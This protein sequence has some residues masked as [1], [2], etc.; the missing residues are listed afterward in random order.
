MTK[1]IFFPQKPN[2][3]PIVYAYEDNHP[4]YKGLLKIGF[5]TRNIEERMAEHYPTLMPGEK[6]YKVVWTDTAMYADGGNF[7]DYQIFNYLNKHGFH[8]VNGEWYR[9]TLNDVKIAY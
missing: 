9:C 4:Q 5:T 2:S 6:P 1:N 7:K 3:Y 8:K